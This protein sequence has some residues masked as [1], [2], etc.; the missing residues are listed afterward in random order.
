MLSLFVMIAGTIM[1]VQTDSS[2]RV[3]AEDM[4]QPKQDRQTAI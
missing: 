2:V 1:R 4:W 3:A